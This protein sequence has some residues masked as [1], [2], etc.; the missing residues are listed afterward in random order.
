MLATPGLINEID[1]WEVQVLFY[2]QLVL[3]NL[4]V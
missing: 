4:L 1:F 2:I 3:M